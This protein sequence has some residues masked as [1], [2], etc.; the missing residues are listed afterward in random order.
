MPT[1]I[2]VTFGAYKY[3]II[4]ASISRGITPLG[5]SAFINYVV[6]WHFK[7]IR[8][9]RDVIHKL[10][11][12]SSPSRSQPALV[13]GQSAFTA[14]IFVPTIHSQIDRT[15]QNLRPH[16]HENGLPPNQLPDPNIQ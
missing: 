14:L 7:F 4:A 1:F 15:F 9:H 12:I 13:R 3:G 5:Y 16:P 11:D 6:S 8:P 10:H 2:G